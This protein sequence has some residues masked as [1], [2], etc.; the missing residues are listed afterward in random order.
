MGL[1]D[2]HAH[3]TFPELRNQVD[4]ILDR[5]TTSGVD[6][7]I[8]VGTDLADARAAVDLANLRSG[9]VYA[10]VGFHPHEAA[11]VQADDIDV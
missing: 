8:T 10:T 4:A 1:I 11:K 7:V 5:C 6:A 2:S 9:T 3:L